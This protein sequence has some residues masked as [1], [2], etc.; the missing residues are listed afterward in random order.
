MILGKM[1]PNGFSQSKFDEMAKD[2]VSNHSCVIVSFILIFFTQTPAELAII[3]S[4]MAVQL[5]VALVVA[6]VI[7]VTSVF[8]APKVEAAW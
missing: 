4:L 5:S 6:P 8:M 2:K 1:D 7:L 3:I